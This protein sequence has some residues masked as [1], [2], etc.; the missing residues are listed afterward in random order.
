VL[1]SGD[2]RKIEEWR[3]EQSRLRSVG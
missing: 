2:H 1:V 3:K